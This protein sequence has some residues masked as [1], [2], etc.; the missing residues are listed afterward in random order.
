MLTLIPGENKKGHTYLNKPA[1]NINDFI[2]MSF[3]LTLKILYTLL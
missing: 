1:A 3:L 2:L